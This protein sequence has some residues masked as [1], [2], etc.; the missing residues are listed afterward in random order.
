M[1]TLD[2]LLVHTMMALAV[3]LVWVV[4]GAVIMGIITEVPLV[5]VLEVVLG[6][7][8][9]LDREMVIIMGLALDQEVVS[10]D[11]EEEVVASGVLAAVDLEDGKESDHHMN[12][13]TLLPTQV[14]H[15]CHP[16]QKS[17]HAN[18]QT[19]PA[20]LEGSRH[21]APPSPPIDRKASTTLQDIE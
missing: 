13:S 5:A 17:H 19:Q 21:R 20:R 6:V 7:G 2:L 12:N 8:L 15:C 16:R 9:D 1:V 14:I 11:R 18:E 4:D 3:D 10:E